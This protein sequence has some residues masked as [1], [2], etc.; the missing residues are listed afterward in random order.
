MI[1]L[2][3]VNFNILKLSVRILLIIYIVNSL[4]II[5]SVETKLKIQSNAVILL[6]PESGRVL[7]AKNEKEKVKIASI[8]K[9]MTGILAVENL[10]MNE[11]VTISKNAAYIGGS[12]INLKKGSKVIV[13]SLIYGMFLESGND[14]AIAV[15]EHIG[16]T[17]ENFVNMMNEKAKVLGALDTKFSNPHGLDTTENYSTAKDVALIMKY[18]INIKEIKEAMSTKSITMNF[19]KVD[20][21]LANTNRLLF[22]YPGCD[23]G[24]T[25]FTNIA[26]RCL[27]VTALKGDMRLICIVLGA[28]TTDI[29]FNEAKDLLNYGFN[30]YIMTDIS[31]YMNWYINIP[32]VKGNIKSYIKYLNSEM[33]V[34]LK[35]K[36]IEE[37]YVKQN[38]V[39]S[40]N[41][42]ARKNMYIGDISMYIKDEKIY[43]KKVYL[44][45]DINKKNVLDYLYLCYKNKFNIF[46]NYDL[47]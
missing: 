38:L 8:T 35:E 17:L 42:P 14:C 31:K 23:A 44:D 11:Q 4:N 22:T 34:P 26:N 6:E 5:Y 16:G 3:K 39:S 20:K 10:A 47:E 27:A 36:E 21:Y 7:Y 40:I 25:G 2:K 46:D 13:K 37:I 28:N 24:K 30:N 43:N 41:L 32:V 9:L 19:A 12:T 1:I 18:A 15:A 29:R 33:I 45:K